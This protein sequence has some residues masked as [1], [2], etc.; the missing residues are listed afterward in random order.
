MTGSSVLWL[1]VGSCQDP[2]LCLLARTMHRELPSRLYSSETVDDGNA[3]LR[4]A[5]WRKLNRSDQAS[6]LSELRRLEENRS[7]VVIF[8]EL[9]DFKFSEQT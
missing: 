1:Q 5:P 4:E 9:E 2:D 7:K 3:T 6:L 8:L